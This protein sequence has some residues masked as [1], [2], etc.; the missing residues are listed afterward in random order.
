MSSIADVIKIISTAGSP[1]GSSAAAVG[2]S[3]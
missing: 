3:F 1:E 2:S